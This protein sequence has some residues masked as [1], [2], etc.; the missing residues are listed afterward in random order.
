VVDPAVV[1]GPTVAR[2][3]AVNLGFSVAM[4]LGGTLARSGFQRL[5]WADAGTCAMV[6]VLAWRGLP[7]GRPGRPGRRYRGRPRPGLDAGPL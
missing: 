4:V 6:G 7:R 2:Y 1:L 3:Q 5:F